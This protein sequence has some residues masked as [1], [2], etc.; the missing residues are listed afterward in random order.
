MHAVL[1]FRC[2][3]FCVLGW[4]TT[5]KQTNMARAARG[6]TQLERGSKLRRHE[7][8]KAVIGQRPL[9]I[10][11]E[12]PGSASGWIPSV[13]PDTPV[14]HEKN[15]LRHPHASQRVWSRKDEPHRMSSSSQTLKRFY[16]L[17]RRKRLNA[18]VFSTWINGEKPLLKMLFEVNV[19]QER[20]KVWTS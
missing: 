5:I 20:F 16:S 18:F 8:M 7:T 19:G 4:L 11:G 10:N 9:K 12:P 2:M 15:K 6:Q 1:L 17:D 14:L 13:A 3:L